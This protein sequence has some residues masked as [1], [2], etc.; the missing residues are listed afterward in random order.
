MIS[1]ILLPLTPRYSRLVA[2]GNHGEMVATHIPSEGEIVAPLPTSYHNGFAP[3]AT[4]EH[5]HGRVYPVD[6]PT[7]FE[8][9]SETHLAYNEDCNHWPYDSDPHATVARNQTYAE[10]LAITRAL[11]SD[12]QIEDLESTR[13][14][15][16]E[17]CYQALNGDA[18]ARYDLYLSTR[19]ES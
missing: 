15:D 4:V 9:L 7:K 17:I 2:M 8:A 6:L 11:L 14:A 10:M 19:T 5:K 3:G 13:E 18:Y 1:A 16:P 12:E